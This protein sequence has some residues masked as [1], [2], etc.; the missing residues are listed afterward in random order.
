[1]ADHMTVAQWA[2]A[3]MTKFLDLGITRQM[4]V[5]CLK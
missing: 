3:I 5:E 4:A 2:G 1:M